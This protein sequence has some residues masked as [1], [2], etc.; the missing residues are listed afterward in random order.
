MQRDSLCIASP[1]VATSPQD[2]ESLAQIE[3]VISAGLNSEAAS[4]GAAVI[5]LGANLPQTYAGPGILALLGGDAQVNNEV[6]ADDVVA[7]PDPASTATLA[8]TTLYRLPGI[9]PEPIGALAKDAIAL[10]DA[11]DAEGEWLRVVNDGAV[12][13][14]E[15]ESLAPL[16]ALEA[17]PRLT[18][19][20]PYPL[21]VFSLT[22]GS[23]YAD[24]PAAEPLVAVQTPED[25]PVNLTV[26]GVDIHVGSMV[27]FQQAHRG[28]LSLTVHRGAVTTIYGQRIEAGESAIG[29][30]SPGEA[31][32]SLAWSGALPASDTEHARGERAQL[33]FNLLAGANGWDERQVAQRSR[34]MA[35]I[36]E[37]GE[38]LYSIA[39]R[40]EASVAEIVAANP[41]VDPRNIP[42]G[43]EL[44][45]PNAGSGFAPASLPPEA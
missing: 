4:W 43:S 28:A 19:G 20:H 8:D 39:R 34:E 15:A 13:W 14:A 35:H 9:I 31:A 45:I 27:S 38:Y 16:Q 2:A 6:A 10:V 23:A 12:A 30:L 36:V 22:T 3:S 11:W 21:R 32:D 44:V 26:N 33:A 37:R 25:A 18:I 40:F 41:H 1:H 29:I 17:L 7:I 42:I 5:H 24:C